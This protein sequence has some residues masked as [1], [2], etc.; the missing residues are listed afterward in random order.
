MVSIYNC[1]ITRERL[2]VWGCS[3]TRECDSM[4]S[5]P[6]ESGDISEFE[7]SLLRRLGSSQACSEKGWIESSLL[8]KWVLYEVSTNFEVQILCAYTAGLTIE[9]KL[10]NFKHYLF[11]SIDF[12][13]ILRANIPGSK[14]PFANRLFS[15]FT[16]TM[17]WSSFGPYHGLCGHDTPC[18]HINITPTLEAMTREIGSSVCLLQPKLYQ[19]Y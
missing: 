12:Y 10:Y 14:K 3:F 18:K 13:S 16:A 7:S 15:F 2:L 9:T 5:F 6:F 11:A 4:L 17:V 8:P 19:A 1:H